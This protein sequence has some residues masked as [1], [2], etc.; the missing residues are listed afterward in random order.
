MAVIRDSQGVV[1]LGI[2]VTASSQPASQCVTRVTRTF[3]R[4]RINNILTAVATPQTG[5]VILA[6]HIAIITPICM[7]IYVYAPSRVLG[8]GS[9]RKINRRIRIGGGGGSIGGAGG[10]I[11]ATGGTI[12]SNTGGIVNPGGAGVG[13]GAG[14]Y[15]GAGGVASENITLNTNE[16]A[17]AGV[18]GGG[19]SVHY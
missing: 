14:Y 6:T 15:G 9:R 18:N 16:N 3:L 1:V 19:K 5:S 10:D 13:G 8:Q 12:E 17:G 7:Y 2:R 11:E 4:E